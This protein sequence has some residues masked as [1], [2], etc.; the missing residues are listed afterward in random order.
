MYHTPDTMPTVIRR[1]TRQIRWSSMNVSSGTKPVDSQKPNV[2]T[3]MAP[4]NGSDPISSVFVSVLIISSNV[5]HLMRH[6]LEGQ[7]R[8]RLEI[9]F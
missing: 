4:L 5:T 1:S 7:V 6:P 3:T 9:T 8:A 2:C